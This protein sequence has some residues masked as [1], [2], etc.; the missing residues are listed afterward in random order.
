MNKKEL[1]QIGISYVTKFCEINGIEMP[2]IDVVENDYWGSCGYYVP[3]SKTITI[4][5]KACARETN[6]PGFSWSHRHYFV[7]REPCGVLCHEFG[8]YLHDI[9]TKNKLV[10]PKENSITSY[11]P[12]HYERFAETIKL[13]ITNPDLLKQYNPK[14]YQIITKKLG[15]KPIFTETWEELMEK[16]GMN[17]KFIQA[18]KNK[19]AKL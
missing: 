16:E 18:T 6:K 19:L 10:L 5:E 3:E 12:N 17:P 2:T 9:L 13:F 15:L 14:R 11:E 4:V 8:H 1:T 7:D